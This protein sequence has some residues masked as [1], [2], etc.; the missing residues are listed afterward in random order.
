MG[1][2][3]SSKRRVRSQVGQDPAA[4]TAASVA[5]VQQLQP[6]PPGAVQFK[7]LEAEVQASDLAAD[8]SAAR[9]RKQ[10]EVFDIDG[11]GW[12]TREEFELSVRQLRALCGVLEDVKPSE[13]VKPEA[14]AEGHHDAPLPPALKAWVPIAKT[15]AAQ[16][17]AVGVKELEAEFAQNPTGAAAEKLRA[18]TTEL[19][20]ALRQVI[21]ERVRE[22]QIVA[23]S[24]GVIE[25]GADAFTDVYDG[26][27][28][29]INMTEE[30]GM[31]SM[32]AELS[33][34]RQAERVGRNG[35]EA[36]QTKSDVVEVYTDAA[37]ARPLATAVVARIAAACGVVQPNKPVPLKSTVR[38]LE[39]A[40]LRPG[41]ARG[42]CE[43]VCDIVRDMVEG[44]STAQLA[45][46]V[47][48]FFDDDAIVVVRLKDRFKHPSGGGWRDIMINYYVA[49]DANK[50]VCEVQLVHKS[51]L[52]ARKGLPGHVI[53]GVV[54]NSTEVLEFLG[55]LPGK[56]AAGLL[57]LVEEGWSPEAIERMGT[58]FDWRED[59]AGA[60]EGLLAKDWNFL[61]I[62]RVGLEVSME[63]REACRQ[64]RMKLLQEKGCDRKAILREGLSLPF[65]GHTLQG[66]TE[67]VTSACVTPDGKHVVTGSADKT[68]RIWLLSD[69]SLVSTLE[70]HTEAVHSV[71]VTP[72]GKHVV[73]GSADRTVRIWLLSDGL[74][75]RTLDEGHNGIVFSVC[76]TPDGKHVVTASWDKTARIWLLS[77][78]SHVRTLRGQLDGD[79][80]FM[81]SVC[82]T[83]NGKHV[84]TGLY[85]GTARIW[86]LSDGSHV[87]TLE[88]HHGFFVRSVCVTP[89]GKHVVTTSGDG[90]ARIWL[91]AD[92]S[93]VHTLE[94]HTEA[95]MSAC[96][97]P[98]GRHVVTG[99]ADKTTRIWLLSD[100][101]LVHTLEGHTDIVRSVCVTPD[102]KHILTA[103]QDCTARIWLLPGGSHVRTRPS[104][105][106]PAR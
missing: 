100:G 60:V 9:L 63:I 78:G 94:G 89:D 70:R 71:C 53:Y 10:F 13:D 39:K 46:L 42:L 68:A 4:G 80:N 50:H 32:A 96:V 41:D 77:D 64:V 61:A 66:H 93:H 26:V 103:S 25:A 11:N 6:P 95:V 14:K 74:L 69:G 81:T 19:A 47:R 102:G 5:P 76:V 3:S 29:S 55:L 84:V 36:K 54:R 1:L 20:A 106:T 73:T 104:K 22:D 82:V 90:T 31:R 75:V 8:W 34:E 65:K 87:R 52:M 79:A 18:K 49:S 24:D 51:L 33:E 35:E 30:A 99:S 45:Q 2:F 44:E 67:S 23:R 48:A 28:K 91:L 38:I 37:A 83:P 62:N 72:D 59:R 86:L 56:R 15:E 101:S 7:D 92:G 105:G 98:D 12:L 58:I 16:E 17:A 21:D 40:L 85:D 97:T 43:R 57:A 88:G 27:A